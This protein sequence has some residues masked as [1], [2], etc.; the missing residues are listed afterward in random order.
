MKSRLNGIDISGWQK[1]L[2]L[3]KLYKQN[4]LDF[5]VLKASGGV[6]VGQNT[7]KG[8]ADWLVKSGKPWGFYH[9][10]NDD[11]RNASGAAEADWF[12]AQTKDYFGKG[13][14]VADYEYPGICLGAEYLKDFCDRVYELTGV[15]PLVYCSRTVANQPSMKC[16]ADGDNKL[17]LAQYPDYDN[18]YEWPE[19]PWQWGSVE[20]FKGF[21][22]QQFTS[23]LHIKGWNW[24]LD[25]DKF[26]GTYDEWDA[27][28]REWFDPDA[29]EPVE[30]ETPSEERKSAEE[31]A[32]EV[33]DGKWG[34]GS[35]RKRRLTEA[36]YDYDAVQK[37]VN[38]IV[39]ERNAKLEEAK[40]H[41]MA[42]GV[43]KGQY[44]NGLTRRLK[45]GSY[46]KKVQ[47][48]V[49]RILQGK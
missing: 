42:L 37:E 8:W 19:T 35:D 6:S 41:Q 30:P 32:A 18:K 28:A 13:I 12:V 10:L 2:D 9:F 31:L 46:Y 34:N 23:T 48:E 49:N 7:F 15:N 16:V 29:D 14:P 4:D 47:D 45:L 44:G 17:W 20:P 25:G 3:A 38:R 5:V 22:M 1:G 33:L 40:I 24:S 27:L 11:Y 26:F 43:I 21:V 39:D 36:G